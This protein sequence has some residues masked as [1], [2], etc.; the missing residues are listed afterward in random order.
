M[1]RIMAALPMGELGEAIEFEKTRS[2][3]KSDN[4]LR[5]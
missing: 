3:L 5:L 1:E 2:G 4:I